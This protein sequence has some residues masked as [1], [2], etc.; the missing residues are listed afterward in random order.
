MA[1]KI[2]RRTAP[3]PTESADLDDRA[4][5]FAAGGDSLPPKAE[6]APAENTK[7]L[8]TQMLIRFDDQEQAQLV[9]EVAR[10][11]HRSKHAT[12]LRALIRGLE[13]IRDELNTAK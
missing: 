7:K 8:P 10:L 13:E 2:V 4:E 3:A 12:A 1:A 9:A 11:D 6:P 5:R